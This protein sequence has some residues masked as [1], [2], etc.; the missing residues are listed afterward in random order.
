MLELLLHDEVEMLVGFS[1]WFP[2]KYLEFLR[3]REGGNLC[4]MR[5]F[6]KQRGV[7]SGGEVDEQIKERIFFFFFFFFF[8]F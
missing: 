6:L 7:I 5:V 4:R 2:R 8:F 1:V 3:K